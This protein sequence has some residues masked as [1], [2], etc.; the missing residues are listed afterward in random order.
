LTVQINKLKSTGGENLIIAKDI[1]LSYPK[2][3]DIPKLIAPTE[4]GWQEVY[5]NRK[6]SPPSPLPIDVMLIVTSK[7]AKPLKQKLRLLSIPNAN[8]N[9]VEFLN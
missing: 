4:E 3:E 8:D 2:P 6:I 9:L 5:K 7:N 1:K